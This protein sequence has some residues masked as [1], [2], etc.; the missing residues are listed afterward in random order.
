MENNKQSRRDFVKDALA[1]SLIFAGIP[2]ILPNSVFGKNAPSKRFNIGAIGC[3][4][5]SQ[6]YDLPSVLKYDTVRVV[7]VCD[8]DLNRANDAQ[9]LVNDHYSKKEGKPY[10]GVKVYQNYE[11][12]LKNK[13]IDAVVIS[14]PDHWHAKIAIDAAKAKKHIFLQKPTSL[15]ITE[16]RALADA[17]KKSG[18][19]FQIGSQQRSSPQFRYAAEL[20]RNGRIGDL[21]R[22]YVGLPGDP[23]GNVEAEMPVPKQFDYNKWLGSTPEAFYTEKRVHPQVGYDRP[24]WLRCEQFGAGMI[25]GWGSHHV[26]AAHWAMNTE[27]SGPK[28]VWGKA[29]FPTSGL[30]NVHGIFQT[31]ALYDNGV[32]MTISNEI[33]NGVKFEGTEGWIFVTRGAYRAT[34]SDP[35]PVN[36]GVKSLDASDPKIITS[37]IGPNEVNLPVSTDHHGNW[38]ESVIA[39]KQPIAPVEVA[40]RSCSTCLIHHIAMKLDR[41]VFWDYKTEKF[42]NDAE[43]NSLLARP[44]RKPFGI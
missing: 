25:T 16:G 27:M 4:R 41:R 20:V 32:Q 26:D 42:I 36:N 19:I 43:A 28:E 38:I 8:L 17:V 13:D 34:P 35:V 29:A 9:K 11:Q 7:A 24:G 1:G 30:W 12:L 37:V 14:T 44:M 15:T 22:V 3:G 21:K 6:T 39:N 10:N 31:E 2:M 33:P 5:I 23:S 18:V 40:H